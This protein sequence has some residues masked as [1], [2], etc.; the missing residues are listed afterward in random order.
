MTRTTLKR[1][2]LAALAAV[3][4]AGAGL[5][6]WRNQASQA[7]EYA[8]VKVARGDIQETVSALGVLV[9]SQYV[10]VG[11]QVSGQIIKLP[12]T[13]GDTVKQGQL[14]AE[15][16]PTQYAAQVGQDQALITDLDAQLEGWQAKLAL[17][18][19]THDRTSRLVPQGGATGQALEQSRADV[20]VAE[21][22]VASL[23]AQIDKAHNALKVD[24]ANLGYTQIRAPIAGLVISPTSAV[25]GNAWSKVDIAHQGQTLN[26][27][28]NAPL[29]MRI[30]NL[31]RMVVRAQ[32]SEADVARLKIGMP[33]NFTTLGR[34]DRHM[35]ARLDAIE[36][37][38]ELVNG[39]IF[40]DAAFEVANPD[41]SLLPQMT[42][43]VFFVLAEAKNALVV[44][45]AALASIQRQSGARIPGCPS[46][47]P[48]ED[49]DCVRVLVDGQP[50]ARP[51]TVGV[52][53]EG[54]AQILGGIEAGDQ[55]IVGIA[56]AP[57]GNGSGKGN[58]G[59]K[60]GG[61]GGR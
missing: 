59:G 3:V 16:D 39:A 29:L 19:W 4:A 6:Y 26:A 52:K 46:A 24:Q 33:V 54:N 43:Q 8:T 60:G 50:V 1:L 61:N 5:A 42:A 12:V 40:Y 11:A 49:S 20:K 38:P 53:N 15:I 27:N 25:Y 23:R 28:Q 41:H 2:G 32:V 58:A 34:P 35:E 21:T 13:L 22:T 17:A 47:P 10:D 36:S 56:G 30:A 55:V 7:S 51:V 45:L 14:V 31:D 18:R 44:P 57:A 9:P 48:S 37:T